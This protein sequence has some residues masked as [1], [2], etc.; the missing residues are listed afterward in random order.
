MVGITNI[1]VIK[2]YHYL[3]LNNNDK[4]VWAKFIQASKKTKWS[5]TILF[6]NFN[7]AHIKKYRN[8]KNKDKI[9]ALLTKL[10]YDKVTW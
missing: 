1:L 8:Y 4:Y 9:R 7:L 6:S 3:S 5:M 2:D 10:L